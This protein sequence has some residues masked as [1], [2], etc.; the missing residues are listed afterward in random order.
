MAAWHLLIGR[1]AP[2]PMPLSPFRPPSPSAAPSCR[3]RPHTGAGDGPTRHP[4][5]PTPPGAAHTHHEQ[6]F[7]PI[8]ALRRSG[9]DKVVQRRKA[10]PVILW[11]QHELDG[12]RR[13]QR[14]LSAARRGARGRLR[15]SGVGIKPGK[16]LLRAAS[17][18]SRH[19][20][21][22]CGAPALCMHAH[23]CEQATVHRAAGGVSGGASPGHAPP[24]P[25]ALWQYW[26]SWP[27][28]CNSAGHRVAIARCL[29]TD[30]PF[31]T[32]GIIPPPPSGTNCRCACFDPPGQP[33]TLR[34][35]VA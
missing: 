22:R 4:P 5:H 26:P 10:P 28:G 7:P 27:Q 6:P 32:V 31:P 33:P 19:A 1:Q 16:A 20:N 14:H 34:R 18:L 11:V 21:L 9:G 8:E 15:R 12:V 30:R 29:A 13:C 25:T 3:P 35:T 2:R 23:T 24:K 17:N